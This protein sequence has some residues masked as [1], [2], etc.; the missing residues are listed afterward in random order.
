[1]ADLRGQIL[2]QRA[3]VPD[4]D[5]S[6]SAEEI[7]EARRAMLPAGLPPQLREVAELI[8]IPEFR[9][10]Y[11]KLLIDITGNIWAAG[12]Y[13][14]T[15]PEGPTEWQVFAPDGQWLGLVRTPARFTV[16]EIG[17]D[18]LLGVFRDDLDVEHVQL[19]GLAK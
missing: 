17:V 11:S 1:M 16:L 7:D 5:L 9:P 10:A 15:G 18:Y 6:L 8:E 14:R 19:L 12:Y 2:T 3:R 4:F 13:P